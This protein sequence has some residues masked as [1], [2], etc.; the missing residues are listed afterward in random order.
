M[1]LVLVCSSA[2]HRGICWKT[3]TTCWQKEEEGRVGGVED[4]S[5]KEGR[6]V[7]RERTCSKR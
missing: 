4:I 2:V 1:R 3:E 6:V 7:K 5:E